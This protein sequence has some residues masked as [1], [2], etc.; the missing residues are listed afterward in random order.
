MATRPKKNKATRA[1]S[2]TRIMA[3]IAQHVT[4]AIVLG[5]KSTTQQMLTAIFQAAIQAQD[6]LDAA[7]STVSAKEQAQKTALAT[8]LAAQALLHRWAEA[9][10]GPESP[11]LGDFGFTPAK[12]ADKTV[13]VKAGAA[14]KAT[15]TRKAK[16]AATAAAQSPT[17]A[18]PATPPAT[19]AKS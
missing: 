18:P 7:R 13:A 4:A 15:A 9:T 6:D 10:F 16:K 17:A 11:V 12:P 3:G 19:P 8:A 2:F 5:G 14:A 1:L